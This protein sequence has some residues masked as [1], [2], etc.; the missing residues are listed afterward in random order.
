M[1]FGG[2]EQ[3]N[4]PLSEPSRDNGSRFG[5]RHRLGQD[6]SVRPNAQKRKDGLPG[7]S[8][9]LPSAEHGF[10]PGLSHLLAW[11]PA[12]VSV[13]QQVRIDQD[14]RCMGPS[15]MSSSSPMLS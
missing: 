13:E 4:G 7:E 12:I 14:H 15:M 11:R 8:D 3:R 9:R 10:Q 1:P 6:T 2:M 5:N